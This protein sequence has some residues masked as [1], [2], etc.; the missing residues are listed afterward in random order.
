MSDSARKDYEPY[1]E[2]ELQEKLESIREEGETLIALIDRLCTE[3]TMA[4]KQEA[5]DRLKLYPSLFERLDRIRKDNEPYLIA[6]ARLADD[7]LAVLD[8]DLHNE[9]AKLRISFSAPLQERLNNLRTP[10]ESFLSLIDR[11]LVVY[12][13]V[14]AEKVKSRLALYP[15]LFERLDGIREPDEPYHAV[16]DRLI[17]EHKIAL[18][19]QSETPLGSSVALRVKPD[20]R[21]RVNAMARGDETYDDAIARIIKEVCLYRTV[22]IDMGAEGRQLLKN[23]DMIIHNFK[24]IIRELLDGDVRREHED[25]SIICMNVDDLV[26]DIMEREHGA[27]DT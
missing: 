12:A 27:D 15:V 19:Q 16:I 20:T 7:R 17:D 18:N 25:T 9:D 3:H 21:D 8:T 5:N 23:Q 11:L 6:V 24:C 22:A 2:P 1:Y 13:S 4:E 10:G 14:E 26:A